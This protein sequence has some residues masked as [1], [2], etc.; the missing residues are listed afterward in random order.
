MEMEGGFCSRPRL[1]VPKKWELFRI[2]D[3]AMAE[4]E[5]VGQ[6]WVWL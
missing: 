2:E 4:A 3:E 5:Q 1:A 6:G